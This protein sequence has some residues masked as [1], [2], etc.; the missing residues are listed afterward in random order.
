MS[1]ASIASSTLMHYVGH[2]AQSNRV[3]W[4]QGLQQLGQDLQAGNLSAAQSD[5]AALQQLNP[6]ISSTAS[7]QSG[8]GVAQDFAQLGKDLQA[9]NTSAA[10]QDYSQLQQQISATAAGVHHHHHHHHGGSS[11]S[12]GSGDLSQLLQQVGH[13]LQAGNLTAAQQAYAT[14]QQ[15]IQA[16][17]P[18]GTAQS[19]SVAVSA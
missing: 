7:T 18:S 14:L 11:G 13:A 19:G 2:Y 4:Q 9:G 1:I 17:E 12:S 15:Q 3:K 8:N 16:L 10:Q 6:Q 5:F